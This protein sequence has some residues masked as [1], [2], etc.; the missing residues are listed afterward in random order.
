MTDW[1][2]KPDIDQLVDE[3]EDPPRK[4]AAELR[5]EEATARE[6]REAEFCR[7]LWNLWMGR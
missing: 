7:G 3:M 2:R 4:T 1:F 5:A 6:R